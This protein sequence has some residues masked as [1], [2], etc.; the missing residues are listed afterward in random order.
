[1][2][3]RLVF[4]LFV[5]VIVA[6]IVVRAII[7]RRMYKAALDQ[8]G[9]PGSKSRLYTAIGLLIAVLATAVSRVTDNLWWLLGAVLAVPFMIASKRLRDRATDDQMVT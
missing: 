1:V 5:V 6:L 7:R 8:S 4:A 9:P 3:Q 2:D